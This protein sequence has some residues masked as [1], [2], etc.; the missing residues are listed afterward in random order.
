[1]KNFVYAIFITLII[2]LFSISEVKAFSYY[3]VSTQK[4]DTSLLENSAKTYS[5]P[6]KIFVSQVTTKSKELEKKTSEWVNFLYYYSI[7]RL[8]L[9]DLPYTYLLDESGIIYQG[10]SGIQGVNTGISGANG[11]IVVGYLSNNPTLT[12][13]AESSLYKMVDELSSNWGIDKIE[14]VR[15]K[16]SKKE[17]SVS[18]LSYEEVSGDLSSSVNELFKNW[19]P[20][21]KPKQK[22]IAKIEKLE[23]SPDIEVGKRTKVKFELK[24]MNDFPWFTDIDPIYVSVANGK[25]SNFSINKVWESFSKPISISDKTILPNESVHIEFEMEA[26]IQVGQ[27]KESFVILKE[28]NSPFQDSSFEIS[29][30]VVKGD[31]ELVK[32]FSPQYGFVNI[33]ECNRHSCKII[34][35]LKDGEV[36]II[37]SEEDGWSKVKYGQEVEGWVVSRFLK[38]I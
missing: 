14:T 29:L 19:K 8:K 2:S 1:M 15:L 6:Q 31:K 36:F 30:N 35:T 34:D 38:K 18:T 10:N 16:I 9:P 32:V 26:K 37:L 27:V 7:T 25:E 20:S 23:Y 22:Y 17:N 4:F 5:T 21:Q 24:N 12:K 13:R 11:T 28:N 33:R 3:S